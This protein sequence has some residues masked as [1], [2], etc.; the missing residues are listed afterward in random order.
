MRYA[1]SLGRSGPPVASRA[2]RVGVSEAGV[3]SIRGS[4]PGDMP[5]DIPSLVTDLR[6]LARVE[7]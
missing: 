5:A 7:H 1:P 6:A 2:M 3:G 4:L